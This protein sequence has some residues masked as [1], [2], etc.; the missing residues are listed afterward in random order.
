M[1]QDDKHLAVHIPFDLYNHLN[2]FVTRYNFLNPDIKTSKSEVV[3]L[4]LNLL[5]K[6]LID[7]DPTKE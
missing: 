2:N 3:E 7:L 6:T 5:F 4:A 1:T